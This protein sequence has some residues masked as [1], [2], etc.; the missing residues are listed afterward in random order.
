[1]MDLSNS[2]PL[3]LLREIVFLGE[4]DARNTQ[5]K[6]KNTIDRRQTQKSLYQANAS[7]RML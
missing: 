7:T 1:M 5:W 2:L 4:N 6:G 3:F